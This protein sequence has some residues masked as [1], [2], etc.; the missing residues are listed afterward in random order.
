MSNLKL[1]LG[2]NLSTAAA[3]LSLVSLQLLPEAKADYSEQVCPILKRILPEVKTYE[4]AG[5][6]AQF[7]IAITE[8]VETNEQLIEFRAGADTNAM[9]NCP[10]ER[11][12]MLAVLKTKTL[13]EG[14]G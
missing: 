7:V 11:E 3:I 8:Q 13:S 12:E 5:A 1:S 4:P 6:K 9:K 2:R 14:M 10:K